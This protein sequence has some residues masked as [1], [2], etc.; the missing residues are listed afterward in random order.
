[1]L[2]VSAPSGSDEEE[3]M[4]ASV[5][6]DQLHPTWRRLR[7]SMDFFLLGEGRRLEILR[8]EAP[9]PAAAAVL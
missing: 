9:A 3:A 6:I 1:M 5:A 7:S 8:R 4:L 2:T